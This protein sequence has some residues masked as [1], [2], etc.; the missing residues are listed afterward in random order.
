MG[1][2]IFPILN[3]TQREEKNVPQSVSEERVR[4]IVEE[5]VQRVVS[6]KDGSEGGDSGVFATIDAAVQGATCAQQHL[7]ALSLEEL[8]STKF[9]GLRL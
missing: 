8:P 3:Q 9:S 7:V 1:P 4:K 5:V 6:G 2:P